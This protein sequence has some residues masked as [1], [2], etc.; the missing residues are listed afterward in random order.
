[1]SYNRQQT[2][3]E[4]PKHGFIWA[5]LFFAFFPLYMIVNISLKSNDQFFNDPWL[6]LPPY[7]WENWAFGWHQIGPAVANSIFISITATALILVFSLF[8]AYF[9]ARYHL[10]GRNIIWAIF[11]ILMFIPGIANLIP[12]FTLLRGLNMLNSFWGLI[13]PA[14]AGGQVVTVYLLTNF[15]EEIPRDLFDSAQIDGA[16]NVQQLWHI[17]VPMSTPILVTV[18]ILQFIHVWNAFILALV[19]LRDEGMY[20]I[21]VKLYQLDGVYIKEWGPLMA[22]YAIAS[23]PLIIIFVF[24]MRV[25][26]RGLGEGA[27]KG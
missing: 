2:M 24:S 15:I 6:P 18:G 4:T 27:I 13:V 23:I 14:V 12:L 3:N 22:A 25:F 9:F 11:L 20:P 8:A 1:M 21:G 17:V 19:I 26:V 16:S 7:H 5:V 10:P